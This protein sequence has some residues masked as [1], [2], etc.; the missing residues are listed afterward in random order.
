MIFKEW[1]DAVLLQSPGLTH[2]SFHA[3]PRDG[4][5]KVSLGYGKSY[6]EGFL[7]GFGMDHPYGPN[8]LFKDGVAFFKKLFDEFTALEPL[9]LW[10]RIGRQWNEVLVPIKDR[11]QSLLQPALVRYGQFFP[12]FFAPVV[13]HRASVLGFHPCPESVLI[14]AL[15]PRG[16]ECA[17]HITS[18]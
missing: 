13:D 1:F 10:K 8:G 18:V 14:L 3:I 5:G 15:A 11:M 9:R 4:F 6:L 16:L 7:D 2:Q 12:A 17:F